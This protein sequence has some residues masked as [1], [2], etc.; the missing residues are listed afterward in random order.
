MSAIAILIVFAFFAVMMYLRWV[1]AIVAV[2]CMALL[3]SLAAGVPVAQ[4]GGIVT[5]GAAKL[6]PVYVTV[7]FGALLGRVTIETGIARTIVNFV[8]EYGGE[9]PFAL[10]LALCVIVAVLF[11]SLAG[12]GGIIMVGSIVLPIMMT[13]GVPRTI[14]A[15]LFLMAFAL[16]YIFNITNWTFYTKYF[17]IAPSELT[18]Y[19]VVLALIDAIALVL[20]A[21]ISF[22]RERGYAT[23]AVRAEPEQT[24]HVPAVA[25]VTPVIPLVLY[26]GL[27]IDAAPAFLI[28]A[29]YGAIVAKPSV[30]VQR[31]VAAAIRGVE[32]IAPALLLFMGI[33][34][35]LVATQQPQFAAALQPL[36]RGD[37]LRN[38]VAYVVLFGVLSPLVLYRGP[39]NPFGVG[40]A[41]FTVLLT[42][43]ALPAV[44]L[45]AAIMAVVQVQNVCDPTNT[46]NVW[47]A[48]FTGVPIDVITKRTLPYQTGVAIAATLAVVIAAPALFGQR[49]FGLFTHA[50]RADEM[51]PGFYAP[52][53]VRNVLAI[54]DG[55]TAL[56]KSAADAAG[57]DFAMRGWKTIRVRDDPN[58]SDCS[59]KRYTAYVRV[60][61]STFRLIEGDDLDVGFRLQDCGGWVVNEWHDHAIVTPPAGLG[62][63]RALALQAVARIA[64]WAASEPVRSRNLLTYGV[65]AR[66]GD[67]PS[68]FYAFFSTIDGNLRAYVR[69][70]GPAYVAGLRSGDIIEKIDGLDWWRYGTYQAQQ[71]AYDGRPHVFEIQRGGRAAEVR[72]SA[73]FTFVPE[74]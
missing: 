62:D 50:A 14:A 68:F 59:Q 51:H 41:I 64:E 10:S 42:A 34:M 48:N 57:A 74:G 20:Y 52:A 73:P 33:G 47:I 45:V 36:V 58:A 40:I 7:V 17:G 49:A 8:A 63:A 21:A 53:S 28:A 3:M 46:A 60:L 30:A 44:V 70:G 11:T 39:L 27:H 19:A 16:G 1:P 4:L 24:Q 67:R 2:P 9:Q 72:L 6:A 37:W 29:A 35:L 56:G 55:G 18:R 32:D 61:T 15:T 23:W 12:L 22:R 54:D 69:A 25:I 5:T 31:F 43:H 13:A 65:A 26:Y 71:R 66:S 38:P